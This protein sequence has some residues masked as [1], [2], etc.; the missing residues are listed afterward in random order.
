MPETQVLAEQEQ[1]SSSLDAEAKRLL[2]F[3]KQNLKKKDLTPCPQCATLV[4]IQ[5]NKCPHCTSDISKHT[6]TV[7]EEL[8]KLNEITA[9][10]YELHKREMELYH[11]E[12]G[13][14]PF[15]IK[16]RDFF[17]EPQVLQDL[18]I[19]LPSLISFFVLILFL[20][21]KASGLV[22]WLVSLLG[23]F[24][25]YFLFDK[26]NLK[27]YV[28]LNL[29]RTVLLFGIIMVLASSL[30]SSTKFWPELSFLKSGI[31]VQAS[32]AMI[33]E[34]PTTNSEVVA[35]AYRGEDL[36]VLDKN[37]SWYKVQTESGKTGWIHSSVVK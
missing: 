19:V 36:K 15:W 33:R 26:W 32:A 29:Y 7:R 35:T 4:N 30:G 1:K 3:K 10:L 18:K 25:I 27:K 22:F 8:K 11:Q 14:K 16:I 34:A 12:T 9:Q 28:T 17:N 2:D 21:S 13:H 6:K 24:L 20:R 37:E 31:E 5:A 23:S